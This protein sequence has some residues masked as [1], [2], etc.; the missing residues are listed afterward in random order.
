MKK[1]ITIILLTFFA[2]LSFLQ[3]NAW[4]NILHFQAEK[5][6]NNFTKKVEKNNPK[7]SVQE[8]IYQNVAETIYKIINKGKLKW[9]QLELI[10]FILIELQKKINILDKN[11]YNLEWKSFIWWEVIPYFDFK[12]NGNQLSFSSELEWDIQNYTFTATKFWNEITFNTTSWP[13][14]VLKEEK[15][16]IAMWGFP[17]YYSLY[18]YEWWVETF[19]WC[20]SPVRDF[21]SKN[22]SW[23]AE[24]AKWSFYYKNWNFKLINKDWNSSE[25]TM[26]ITQN[27]DWFTFSS[28][29]KKIIL[30]MRPNFCTIKWDETIYAWNVSG[31]IN[32]V[33]QTGCVQEVE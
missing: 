12:T 5:I 32:W 10:N 27:W 25:H 18:V 9:Q 20:A 15:C 30:E 13:Y 2:S 3:T 29:D 14:F 8:Q 1:I 7:K 4:W 21:S 24:S 33:Y 22:F 28:I 6:I 26:K 16:F 11:Y 31:H 17:Y 19:T 23:V